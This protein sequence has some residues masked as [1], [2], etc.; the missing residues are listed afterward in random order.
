MSSWALSIETIHPTDHLKQ[1]SVG[2][3]TSLLQQYKRDML[4][5]ARAKLAQTVLEGNVEAIFKG[6]NR[7]D[8]D[9][10]WVYVGRP[11]NDF[12][13]LDLTTGKPS[14]VCPAPKGMVY[15]IFIKDCGTICNWGWK[16]LDN[17][18]P[19]GVNGDKVYGH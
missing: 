9:R 6:W 5:L 19:E 2:F 18:R 7:S 3:E 11:A 12:R 14:I 17:D 16:Q 10:D 13:K 8:T 1:W 15:A 4:I